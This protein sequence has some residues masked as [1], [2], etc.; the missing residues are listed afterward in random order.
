MSVGFHRL[1]GERGQAD[2][3]GAELFA[4]HVSGA[5]QFHGPAHVAAIIADAK[6]HIEL[7]E[8]QSRAAMPAF[9][10][11]D[12]ELAYRALAAVDAANL[13]TGPRIRASA[14]PTLTKPTRPVSWNTTRP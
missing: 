4:E 13:A 11:S 9:V 8:D 12:F 10:P 1:R 2:P 6:E 14:S 7:L 5:N 3:P